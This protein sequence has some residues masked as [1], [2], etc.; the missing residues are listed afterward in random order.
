MHPILGQKYCTLNIREVI[1]RGAILLVNTN[2]SAVGTEIASLVGAS[3]LKLVDTFVRKQGE[4]RENET[5][6]RRRVTL[7]V[8]EM[9]SL[10]GVDFQGML[11]EVGKFGGSLILATQSLSRLDELSMTMRDSI[12]SNIGVL[13]CF[14]VNAVDAERLLPELRSEYLTE[15]DITGLP[16]HNAYVRVATAGEVQA[17]F[18]MQVLPPITEDGRVEGVV[19][20]GSHNYTRDADEVDDELSYLVEQRLE[21]FRTEIQEEVDSLLMDS[22]MSD[23]DVSEMGQSKMGQKKAVVRIIL[24]DLGKAGKKNRKRR[25]GVEAVASD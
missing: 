2:Q 16:Q 22:S 11:S 25:R 5:I 10:Q 3:V 7:I 6:K 4:V 14:Q 19:N 12:L 24:D 9:Q 20:M 18:T 1:E 8:D 17:P 15:A 23:D 21:N 13:V